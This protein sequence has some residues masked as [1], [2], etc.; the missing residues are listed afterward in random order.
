M[1]SVTALCVWIFLLCWHYEYS[2]LVE[3]EWSE[4]DHGVLCNV[5]DRVNQGQTW[6]Y[7]LQQASVNEQQ[8]VWGTCCLH[9]RWRQQVWHCI[10]DLNHC[11][12]CYEA[13]DSLRIIM[14]LCLFCCR[15]T[16]WTIQKS[17]CV[18]LWLQLHILTKTRT[19]A[20]SGS[21]PS[22]RMAVTNILPLALNM[23]WTR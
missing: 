7:V 4:R 12:H 17:S 5:C 3:I 11:V 10:P 19:F 18:H 23:L 16:L 8:H 6:T 20:R 1:N 14:F 15:S 13:L 9:W 2:F 21:V 22:S